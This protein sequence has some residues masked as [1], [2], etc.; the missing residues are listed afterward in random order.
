MLAVNTFYYNNN[1]SHKDQKTYD[2]EITTFENTTFGHIMKEM[3]A[4]MVSLYTNR[5]KPLNEQDHIRK[6]HRDFELHYKSSISLDELEKRARRLSK[7]ESM[8]EYRRRT[9]S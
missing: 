8:K 6:D 9:A 4:Y 1:R 5:D 3:G 2:V 7:N